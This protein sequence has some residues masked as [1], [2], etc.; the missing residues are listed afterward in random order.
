MGVQNLK[1][2]LAQKARQFQ[3]PQQAG[4]RINPTAQV[5]FHDLD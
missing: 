4:R 3:D 5:N 2:L 1:S